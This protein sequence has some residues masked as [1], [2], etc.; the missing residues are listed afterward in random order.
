MSKPTVYIETTVVSVLT[1]RPTRDVVQAAWQ[2]I[3]TEWW[4]TRRKEF[5]LYVSEGVIVEAQSGDAEAAQRRLTVLKGLPELDITLE[6]EQLAGRLARR[7]AL[8][9]R[10]KMDAVHVAV[11][12]VHRIDFLLTWNCT[13]LANPVLEA[14]ARRICADENYDSPMI[15]TPHQLLEME[16]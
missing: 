5:K 3:T 1:S 14:E 4:E 7:L 2:Q 10:K 9:P 12:A 13:H 16:L 11:C 8:P 15:C 6:V